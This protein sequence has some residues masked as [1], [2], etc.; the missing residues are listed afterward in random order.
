M[1]TSPNSSATSS[2]PLFAPL[3]PLGDQPNPLQPMI[4]N[5]MAL[6]DGL[7]AVHEKLMRTEFTGQA[8]GVVTVT[9]RGGVDVVGVRLDPSA[10]KRST[11]ELEALI[12]EA[13]QQAQQ[14]ARAYAEEVTA[15][16]AAAEGL[17]F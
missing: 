13:I 3:D 5:M 12:L 2:N 7:M 1:T 16:F 10:R 17:G 6:R 9:V 14:A 15:P 11:A 8:G 4:D